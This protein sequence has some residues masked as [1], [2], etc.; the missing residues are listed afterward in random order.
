MDF[1]WAA[2]YEALCSSYAFSV[3]LG[4]HGKE[5]KATAPAVP[6]QILLF[7][8]PLVAWP[9]RASA[10]LDAFSFCE[11]CLRIRPFQQVHDGHAQKVRVGLDSTPRSACATPAARVELSRGGQSSHGEATPSEGGVE[12]ESS[13]SI[14]DQEG[15][16]LWFCSRRCHQQA[17]GVTISAGVSSDEVLDISEAADIGCATRK[18][19]THG[20]IKENNSAMQPDEGTAAASSQGRRIF[21]WQE[22]LSSGALWSLRQLDYQRNYKHDVPVE[23]DNENPIGL[24]ALGRIVARVAATAAS[25][26]ETGRWGLE[27]AYA[28]AC[29][30]FLRFAGAEAAEACAAFDLESA[31]TQLQ[32]AL[33]TSITKVLGNDVADALL[34][35]SALAFFF[36]VLMRNSQSLLIWGATH[37]GTLMVVR[38]AGLYVLQACCNHSCVPNCCV[39]NGADA[40]ISL[41][42]ERAIAPGEELTITYVPLT[43]PQSQRQELLNSYRFIC[44]CSRCSEEKQQ[45][46]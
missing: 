44:N 9:V 22:F 37:E 23:E 42:A 43:L 46:T 10:S 29:R 13:V 38:A 16:E 33:S 25:L 28:E 18:R 26:H 2:D 5:L 7:E 6:G 31:S 12:V 40:C 35:R 15:R 11:N 39:E 20:D 1:E 4:P 32:A 8:S 17:F 36:G 24:E 3:L 27:D 45:G 14:H 30:P 21:G 34:G 19:G 41:K